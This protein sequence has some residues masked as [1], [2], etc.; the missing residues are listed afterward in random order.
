MTKPRTIKKS[1]SNLDK[2]SL[3]TGAFGLIVNIITLIAFIIQ[4]LN[5]SSS[6]QPIVQT[7]L[8]SPAGL[9]V[10]LL[11]LLYSWF[12]LSW[13]LARRYYLNLVNH[14]TSQHINRDLHYIWSEKLF[15]IV[16]SLG[17]F[18]LPIWALWLYFVLLLSHSGQ[19]LGKVGG[20]IALGLGAIL[21]FGSLMLGPLVSLGISYILQVVMPIIHPDIEVND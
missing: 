20:D 19:D 1:L 17:L 14:A 10:L 5:A 16:G 8:P 3:F 15:T 18:T 6:G 4:F 11:V 21:I 7:S 2:F 12:T 13:F 9:F